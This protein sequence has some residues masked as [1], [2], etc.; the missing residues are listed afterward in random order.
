MAFAP[1]FRRP[2]IS[3]SWHLGLKMGWRLFKRANL[4]VAHPS[5]V[6]SVGALR[7]YRLAHRILDAPIQKLDIKEPLRR[8]ANRIAVLKLKVAEPRFQ[9]LGIDPPVGVG[10][11]L[12]QCGVVSN[13]E[14]NTGD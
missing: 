14:K 9:H 4:F 11:V 1:Q 8:V 6:L 10:A 2:P 3:F 13:C 12:S 5:V 7:G